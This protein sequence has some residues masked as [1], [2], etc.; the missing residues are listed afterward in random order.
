MRAL[1]FDEKRVVAGIYLALLLF[2]AA[3]H[4]LKWGVVGDS[5]NRLLGIV[6]FIGVIG[7]ARLVPSMMQ[8][9]HEYVEAR[10][11]LEAK[12]ESERDKSNDAADA[13]R[14]RRAIGMPPESSSEHMGER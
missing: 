4:Y 10:R 13:E 1:T 2:A 7:M 9:M 3:N 11:E 6:M 5:G 14:V 12:A 8:E